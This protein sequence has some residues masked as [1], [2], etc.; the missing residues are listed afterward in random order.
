MVN[1]LL[2]S[3]SGSNSLRVQ[4]SLFVIYFNCSVLS[5]N[6]TQPLAIAVATYAYCLMPFRQRQSN[7]QEGCL[8]SLRAQGLK[9]A[10]SCLAYAYAFGKAKQAICVIVHPPTAFIAP[11]YASIAPHPCPAL[12]L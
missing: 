6:Y 2:L 11:R 10:C 1:N 7:N 12:C 4:V 5:L 3:R 8:C 9:H